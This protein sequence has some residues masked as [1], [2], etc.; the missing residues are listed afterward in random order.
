[1]KLVHYIAYR[2][3]NWWPGLRECRIRDGSAKFQ[4][5]GSENIDTLMIYNKSG[6]DQFFAVSDGD[7]FDIVK[8]LRM[9]HLILI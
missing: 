6:A 8:I 9:K 2:M 4:K 7:I 5:V 1:M 3:I